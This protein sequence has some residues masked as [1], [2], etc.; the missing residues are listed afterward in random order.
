MSIEKSPSQKMKD[1]LNLYYE[2]INN[3]DNIDNMKTP[4]FEIRFGSLESIPKYN[5]EN[6]ISKLKSLGFTSNDNY[7]YDMLRISLNLD[8][9]LDNIRLE[10]EDKSM[11]QKVC[12]E[13]FKTINE[14]FSLPKL[15][16]NV[17]IIKK[18]F[19]WNNRFDN[20]DFKFRVSYQSE[21]RINKELLTDT[22]Q[23]YSKIN[24]YYRC[25]NRVE[26]KHPD[27]P[28]ICHFSIVKSSDNKNA[29]KLPTSG[30][31]QSYFK[32]EIEIELD[33]NKCKDI[34]LEDLE[35][36]LKILIKNVLCGIQLTNYPISNREI[37]KVKNEYISLIQ[38]FNLRSLR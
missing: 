16:S 25:L 19:K 30:L 33:N 14:I 38:C 15:P 5:F 34:T 36:K 1:L 4:E 27:L 13:E 8:G 3:D 10:I 18:E 26:Y 32:Y 17:S 2:F 9:D 11:I 12:N 29:Y 31:L 20:E 6:T 37:N 28:F 35:L 22:I 7:G 23:N 21:N 24:K